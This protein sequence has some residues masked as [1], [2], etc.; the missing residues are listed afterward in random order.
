MADKRISP[1]DT[2][3]QATQIREAWTNINPA[4]TYG[5]MKIADFA[6]SITAL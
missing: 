6:A 4:N 5:D 3:E 2:R 1:T